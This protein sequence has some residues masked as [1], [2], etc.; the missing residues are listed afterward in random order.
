[1]LKRNTH[2]HMH[3]TSIVSTNTE[4]MKSHKETGT[5]QRRNQKIYFW[6]A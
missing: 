4:N 2:R 1:M 6:E 3:K 5:G